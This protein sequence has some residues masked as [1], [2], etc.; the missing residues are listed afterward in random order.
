MT[1]KIF[2][3]I[4][5][6]TSV[7]VVSLNAEPGSR[8]RRN[9]KRN[10]PKVAPAIALTGGWN[11]VNGEWI[12]SDGYKYVNGQLIRTGSQTHKLPPKPPTAAQLKSAGVKPT[13]TPDPNSAAAKAAEKEKNLRQRPASQTGTHL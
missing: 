1:R 6:M 11:Y 12:H 13:P 5:L 3:L 7:V 8:T 9:S 2:S 10:L 4:V